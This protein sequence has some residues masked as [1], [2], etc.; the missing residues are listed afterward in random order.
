MD[1]RERYSDLCRTGCASETSFFD[2]IQPVVDFMSRL[3]EIEA[4]RLIERLAKLVHVA[5]RGEAAWQF[6]N[7]GPWVLAGLEVN[8]DV[9]ELR[10]LHPPPPFSPA[11]RSIAA[12]KLG[13]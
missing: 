2:N 9:E 11:W 12:V 13:E 7:V 5:T 1:D 8:V 10:R 4:D 3:R 6:F